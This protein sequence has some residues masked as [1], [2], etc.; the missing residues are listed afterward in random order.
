VTTMPDAMLGMPTFNVD[1]TQVS[2]TPPAPF[3]PSTD[4]TVTVKGQDTSQNALSGSTQFKFST[5]RPPDT[6]PPTVASVAPPN[7]ATAVANNTSIAITFSEAMNQAATAMAITTSPAVACMG[8]W[9]WNMAGTTAT[10]VPTADLPSNTLYSVNVS[11]GARDLAGNTMAAAFASSFTTGVAPDRTPPTIVSVAPAANTTGVIRTATIAVTFSE[12]MDLAS[13]QSAFSVTTPAGV[14]GTFTWTN[15]NKTMTFRP[16]ASFAYGDVVKFQVSNA[17]KDSAGNAKSTTDVYQF[18]VVRSATVNLACIDALDGFVNSLPVA[19]PS[20]NLTAGDSGA[21]GTL[22]AYEAFDLSGLPPETTAITSAF[23]YVNQYSVAGTPYGAAT[24]GDLLWDHVDFGPTLEA[25]DYG[26]PVLTHS[27][28][29][30]ILSSSATLGWKSAT[31]LFA[32]LDDWSARVA[33]GNR[34]EFVFKFTRDLINNSMANYAYSYPC[35]SAN[36][37]LRPYLAVTY[38]YP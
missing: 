27:Y 18:T 9:T 7:G 16:A 37:T 17:A 22:R 36:A 31:V 12:A 11:T 1:K 23:I 8:G 3:A 26:T 6:T 29:E 2:F 10:C 5:A 35:S 21:G 13:S 24:L 4:Y 20:G 15:A 14:T 38:E 28:A 32:V 34:S 25:T 33:R 30:G 19:Y